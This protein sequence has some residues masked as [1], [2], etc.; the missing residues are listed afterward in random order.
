MGLCPT[1]A[2]LGLDTFRKP[3]AGIDCG[4]LPECVQPMDS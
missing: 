4:R 1:G 3:P 2:A